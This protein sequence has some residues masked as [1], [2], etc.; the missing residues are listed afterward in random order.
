MSVDLFSK[1]KMKI[2]EIIEDTEMHLLNAN[3]E[4]E[5]IEAK[6]LKASEDHTYVDETDNADNIEKDSMTNSGRR[7]STAS[8]KRRGSVRRRTS[9]RKQPTTGKAAP[10]PT[11]QA[12]SRSQPQQGSRSNL[13][14]QESEFALEI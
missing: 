5:R 12:S 4:L 8:T 3:T 6:R 14:L 9:T 11:P 1:S 10:L 13:H 7:R 2:Y